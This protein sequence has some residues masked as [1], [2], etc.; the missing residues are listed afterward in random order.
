MTWT[1]V[2]CYVPEESGE[3]RDPPR[4]VQYWFLCSKRIRKREKLMRAK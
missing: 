2:F 3:R 1:R 4:E